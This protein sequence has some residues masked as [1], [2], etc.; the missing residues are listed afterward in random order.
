VVAVE[1]ATTNWSQVL[2]ARDGFGTDA[3]RALAALCEA[4]WYPLYAYVRRQGH[5]A[6]TARDLTQGFFAELLE[7][8]SLQNVD[9]AAG[10]FRSYL[11]TSLQHFLSH[12]RDKA[13]ALK[14]GGG[15]HTISLDTGA[16]EKRFKLEPTEALT[17][18]TVFERG[19][20]LTVLELTLERLRLEA[21]ESGG[22]MQFERLKAYLTG[23][24]PRI[25]YR[26]VAE[27]LAMTE[28]AV[29]MA[30]HRLRR[31][32]GRLLRAEI[33]ETVADPAEVDDEVRHMLMAISPLEAPPG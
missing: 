12:E 23:E 31:R 20:A 26:E 2:T 18:E 17:P 1:F 27:E 25:P 5:D 4:Y 9:P 24:E 19:W 29:K 6:D 28:G 7:K 14:R 13:R 22:G 33:A 8:D 15:T 32:F 11:L 10:R 21:V 3:R 16:A 30:V